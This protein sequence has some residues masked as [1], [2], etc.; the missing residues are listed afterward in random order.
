M[1]LT[2]LVDI[3]RTLSLFAE[4]IAGRFYHLKATDEFKGRELDLDEEAAS[5]DARNL[6]LPA[7]IQT[8]DD[9]TLNR[10]SYRLEVLYQLGYR[11]F[12]TYAFAIEKARAMNPRLAALDMPSVHRESDIAVLFAHF[13]YPVLAKRLFQVIE[14]ARIRG[15][16]LRRYPGAQR[17][18][19]A[20]T[21]ARRD[22]AMM[23]EPTPEGYVEALELELFGID[24]YP[25]GLLP[26]VDQSAEADVYSSARAMIDCYHAMALPPPT[27]ELGDLVTADDGPALEWLQREA[28]LEDWEEELADLDAQMVAMEIAE[29]LADE[30][31]VVGDAEGD[32][33]GQTREVDLDIAVE[34][35]QL[36][37]RIDMEKSALRHALGEE[38]DDARSF[39]YD[40]WDYHNQTYIRGWCRL[41]EERL[42]IDDTSDTAALVE[43]IRPYARSVRR[44]FEQIRPGGYQRQNHVPDGDELDLNAIVAA[45]ADIRVGT[46]P[47]E[48]V[49]SRRERVRR[50]VGAAFLVDLSASTDDPIPDPD[51]E[52]EEAKPIDHDIRDPYFDEDEEYDW[53]AH[54][55]AE[56]ARR[57]IIHIQREA[58]LVMASALEGLG[59]QYGIYG[60]SGY[61]HDCV[62]YFVAKEF[63]DRFDQRT[64][65]AIAAMKPKRSTRMGP[66]IRHAAKKLEASGTAL[67]VLLII[68]DGFPQDCDY[69][70]DRGQHEYGL[71]D[72]AKALEEAARLGIET[73][74]VTVDRSG[75]DYLRRMCPDERYMVIEEI[76][77]LPDALQKAYRQLTQ[78]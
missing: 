9:D 56:A 31:V 13:D 17:Y 15:A 4:G 70:P 55:A 34:R 11:E 40:E 36:K 12:G 52:I 63:N 26:L 29:Q 62:E 51:A 22:D 24:D 64:L 5:H 61:G 27:A 30:D 3:E 2:E 44:Q 67:K 38:R 28:R 66:A 10:A 60:F 21:A 37:R 47:D 65:D 78:I 20:V 23:P 18:A 73:F 58:V 54:L 42:A 14:T 45:R 41:Y 57:R 76:E 19:R 43:T 77:E 50:D 46:S 59:D 39:L 68:S 69:G 25:S 7:G 49:Y 1:A 8:F 75:N 33:D 32:A 53:E 71:Q 16:V 48:R 72:T 35:D 6:F 74:C